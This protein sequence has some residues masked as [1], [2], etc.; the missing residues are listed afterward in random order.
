MIT[1]P[2]RPDKHRPA[3]YRA[4]EA[5][6]KEIDQ[7]RPSAASRGYDGRWRKARLSFLATHPLCV[8][9]E[10][11]GIV[12]AASEVDHIIPHR[13][14]QTLFWNQNNWQGLCKPCHSRKTA[15]EAFQR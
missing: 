10:R 12:T 9:C 2:N 6:K 5:V 8:T 13:G 3:G 1:M 15:R 7:N 4:P 14:D 11:R